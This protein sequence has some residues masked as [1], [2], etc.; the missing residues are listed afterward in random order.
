MQR[1]VLSQLVIILAIA[2]TGVRVHGEDASGAASPKTVAATVNGQTVSEA[3]LE[4]HAQGRLIQLQTQEYTLKRQALD[5]AIEQILLEQEAARRGVTVRSLVESE[6]ESKIRPVTDDQV[7]AVYESSKDRSIG[8]ADDEAL[9]QV[10]NNLL[11]VR[12]SMR[13][14][15]FL[16]QL[17]DRSTV[18]IYL[19]APRQKINAEDTRAKGPKNA[20]VTIVEFAEFQCPYCG[21]SVATLRQLEE[22]YGDKIR[23][24]FRD[25]PLVGFHQFAAKAAEAASCGNEQGKFWEIYDKLFANQ[26][27]LKVPA[28]KQYAVDLNLNAS[29]FDQCLDSGKYAKVWQEDRDAGS[30]YGVTGTPTFFIN[31]RMLVGNLPLDKFSEM[32]DEELRRTGATASTSAAPTHAAQGE[33]RLR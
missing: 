14:A 30:Q 32:I 3:E 15:E 5:D 9:S 23:L 28:L 6:I 18:A 27:N 29:Q 19:D 25:F 31:G 13:R 4:A 21:Q 2:G 7:E 20:P 22:K 16:K 11:Q 33:F 10:R 1:Y 17:R 26:S 8:K 24:V 12:I